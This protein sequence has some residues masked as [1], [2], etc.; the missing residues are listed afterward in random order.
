MT[1]PVP[2]VPRPWIQ[3]STKYEFE[4]DGLVNGETLAQAY[5][6][7]LAVV[8]EDGVLKLTV[9]ANKSQNYSVTAK[10]GSLTIAKGTPKALIYGEGTTWNSMVVDSAGHTGLQL[11]NSFR[12]DG[13][14]NVLDANGNI[15]TTS[16]N[17]KPS[18][19][20]AS[21]LAASYSLR[22]ASLRGAVT[23]S[24]NVE[25]FTSVEYGSEADRKS[26]V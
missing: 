11:E 25:S 21:L 4:T 23:P 20:S 22:S 15:L 18:T 9:E 26:V 12:S 8:E 10:N 3:R 13:K 24:W 6:G 2:D 16:I 17:S 14:V 1:I 7:T 5:T 19:Q